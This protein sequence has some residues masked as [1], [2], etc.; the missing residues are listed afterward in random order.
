MITKNQVKYIQSLGQKKPRDAENLFIAEGPKIV[1]ELVVAKN[2]SIKQIYAVKEWIDVNAMR[3]NNVE[4]IEITSAELEKISQLTTPNQVLAVVEKLTWNKDIDLKGTISLS[5]ESI[6]D[7]GNMGSIIRLADWF[8]VNNIFC[9]YDCADVYNPKVVQSSMGSF[10]RVR[11]EYTDLLSLLQNNNGIRSYAAVLNGRDVTKMEKLHEGMI[12]IGNESKGIS[13][14][15]LRQ[16]NVQITVPGKG[17]AESLNAAV[18]TGIILS[19]LTG[20]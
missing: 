13:D 5:L 15:I 6:Q 16:S 12:I 10:A 1:N 18:A 8:G 20:S 11:V 9:S 4:V 2:S 17:E 19:H 3:A 14:K 7:P